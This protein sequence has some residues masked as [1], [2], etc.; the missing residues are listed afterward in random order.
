MT[1]TDEKAARD[2]GA[3]RPPARPPGW[4]R[5]LRRYGPVAAVVAL[6]AGAVV[7]FGGGGG[8]GDGGDGEGT[9]DAGIP[10]TEELIRSGM[11]VDYRDRWLFATVAIETGEGERLQC[12]GALGRLYCPDMPG[13]AV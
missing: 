10:S 11:T 6:V 8:D 13:G 1:T 5:A 4:G 3:G 2:G 12:Y 9:A 7:V